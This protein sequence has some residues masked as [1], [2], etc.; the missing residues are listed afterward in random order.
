MIKI[1]KISKNTSRNLLLRN[2]KEDNKKGNVDL[3]FK[4]MSNKE[5]IRKFKENEK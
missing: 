2:L 1:V 3:T 5:K 4:F